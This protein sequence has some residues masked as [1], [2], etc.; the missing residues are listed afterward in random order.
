MCTVVV[1][2]GVVPEHPLAVV[3]NRDEILT[4]PSAPPR[5]LHGSPR[6]IGGVDLESGGS[7]MGANEHGL[8]VALT[9]Q[10][11]VDPPQ[12]DRRSRGEVV[13]DALAQH[14][15][16]A[17]VSMLSSLD[18]RAY[19]PFNLIFGTPDDVRVAYARDDRS[20]IE[21]E[22]VPPGI[23]VLPNDRLRSPEFP[24]I[25]RAE[26]RARE[27]LRHRSTGPD[28]STGPDDSA[29]LRV[30]AD[31]E[32]PPE[33]AIAPMPPSFDGTARFPREIQRALQALCVHLPFYGTVSATA[34]LYGPDGRVA[35]YLFA[36]GPPCATPFGDVT[37]LLNG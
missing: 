10:R 18:A 35:R 23:S 32:L 15:A 29:L 2:R 21:I 1:L 27:A 36:D 28:G 30:L 14:D 24:K 12:R 19:N 31:H 33:A 20:A 37:A 5:L 3:A 7:W 6:A 8:F 13:V 22:R 11:S 17:V 25:A 16:A 34:I 26:E 9:N 4:R